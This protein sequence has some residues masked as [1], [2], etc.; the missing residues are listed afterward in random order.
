[1]ATTD[2]TFQTAADESA[3][4]ALWDRRGLSAR[5]PKDMARDGGAISDRLAWVFLAG[6][7]AAVRYVFHEAP[8]GGWVVFAASEDQKNPQDNPP[9]KISGV[10]GSLVLNGTKS[11]VAGSRNVDHLIVTARDEDDTV[12]TCLADAHGHGVTLSHREKSSFLQAMSQGFAR[13]E[14]CPV[15]GESLPSDRL[16]LFM[17]SESRFIML[18]C[19]AFMAAHLVGI[20]NDLSDEAT[21]LEK[22]FHDLAECDHITSRG[23]ADLDDRLQALANKFDQSLLSDDIPDWKADKSL[24]AMYSK[25]IQAR[26]AKSTE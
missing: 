14:N 10:A 25:G 12:V 21:A 11:W 4:R 2:L 22:D 20:E 1:M 17:R 23:L 9:L 6:Y 16:K 18:A 26:A 13:F 24:L 19:T 8:V 5:A 3:F 15:K 7:Q